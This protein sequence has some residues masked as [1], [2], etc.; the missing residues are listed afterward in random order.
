MSRLNEVSSA[1]TAT[2]LERMQ[3]KVGIAKTADP[4][5]MRMWL[6]SGSENAVRANETNYKK[7]IFVRECSEFDP[8]ALVQEVK[9][10]L[11]DLYEQFLASDEMYPYPT[12]EEY[13]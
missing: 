11:L 1:L 7:A 10:E 3:W 8:A 5:E 6:E 4:A 9:D 13:E 12:L 2:K